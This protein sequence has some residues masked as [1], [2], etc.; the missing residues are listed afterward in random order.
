MLLPTLVDLFTFALDSF[1]T[2][3]TCKAIGNLL[4][5]S[6]LFF[7][8]LAPHNYFF[9]SALLASRLSFGINVQF[10]FSFTSVGDKIILFQKPLNSQLN[11]P[12]W[13]YIYLSFLSIP[14]SLFG[15][16]DFSFDR[17][18]RP[19]PAKAFKLLEAN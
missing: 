7:S 2:K 14:L 5:K 12:I 16:L 15:T 3:F 17:L 13:F 18:V 9:V 8:K 19:V 11:F 4:S 10:Y 6:F 1:H